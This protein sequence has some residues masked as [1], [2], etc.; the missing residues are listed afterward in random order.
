MASQFG[1]VGISKCSP[2]A[3][4]E[5]FA[6]SVFL[7]CVHVAW[8]SGPRVSIV[9]TAFRFGRTTSYLEMASCS[10]SL[11]YFNGGPYSNVFRSLSLPLSSFFF[12]FQIE[13]KTFL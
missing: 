11:I 4:L 10:F 7:L 12:R 2:S 5:A 8:W 9:N 6:S 13:Y 1:T 3:L